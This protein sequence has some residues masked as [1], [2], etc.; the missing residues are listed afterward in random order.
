MWREDAEIQRKE[1]VGEENTERVNIKM[2]R[3]D[4]KIEREG[5]RLEGEEERIERKTE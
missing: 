5:V 1:I 4:G 3:D 2:E